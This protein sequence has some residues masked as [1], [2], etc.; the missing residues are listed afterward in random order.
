MVVVNPRLNQV[1]QREAGKGQSTAAPWSILVAADLELS[2][3]GL[4][5][6]SQLPGKSNF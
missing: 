6:W 4:V 1:G 5:A 2:Q 3:E